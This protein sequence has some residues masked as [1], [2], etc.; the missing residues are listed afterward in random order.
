MQ[1]PRYDTSELPEALV[2]PLR[3]CVAVTGA[4]AEADSRGLVP[5]GTSKSPERRCSTWPTTPPHGSRHRPR[6][7]SH[8][9]AGTIRLTVDD[10]AGGIPV[11]KW[12]R[13]GSSLERLRFIHRGLGA[14]SL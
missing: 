5:S 2:W 9:S 8:R 6:R 4:R 1:D 7:T 3:R 14:T 10:D 13:P 11:G 12:C